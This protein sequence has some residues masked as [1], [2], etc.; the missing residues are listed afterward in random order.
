VPV[1]VEENAFSFNRERV[2]AEK[3]YATE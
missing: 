3:P 2:D 1:T